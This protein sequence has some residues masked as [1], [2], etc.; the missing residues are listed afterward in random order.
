MSQST[1]FK[2]AFDS[3]SK[4]TQGV[5][6]NIIIDSSSDNILLTILDSQV[7]S[8]S[9]AGAAI[10]SPLVE[11]ETIELDLS[12][13][14]K[15]QLAGTI[16]ALMLD[17]IKALKQVAGMSPTEMNVLNRRHIAGRFLSEIVPVI[18]GKLTLATLPNYV[19]TASSQTTPVTDKELEQ[20]G[21]KR[22]SLHSAEWLKYGKTRAKPVAKLVFIHKVDN[23]AAVKAI[24]A[25]LA[26][27]AA[28]DDTGKRIATSVSKSVDTMDSIVAYIDLVQDS[29]IEEFDL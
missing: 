20:I 14:T 23:A 26:P 21:I 7:V 1:D 6:E 17:N 19:S 12:K 9:I 2:N 8:V 25:K 15:A 3:S 27:F 24:E 4:H 10:T 29:D 18:Q 22:S 13:V 16:A 28:Y 5:T 11:K